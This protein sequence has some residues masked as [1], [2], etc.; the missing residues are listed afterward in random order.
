M[1]IE[2]IVQSGRRLIATSLLDRARIQDR[3]LVRDSTGGQVESFTERPLTEACRFVSIKDDDPIRD[4][5]S[6]FGRAE[7][8]CSFP[9]AT[10]VQEGDRIRNLKGAGT[11]LFR[12][13]KILT[14]PSDV[15]VVL[16]AGIKEEVV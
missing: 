16:R 2:A 6:I 10:L 14:P 5:D 1:S 11:Q 8:V 15:I 3:A 7:M 13:V 12:V 4:L 9:V